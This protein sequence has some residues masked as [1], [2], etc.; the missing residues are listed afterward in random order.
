MNLALFDFD[1]TISS[2]DSFLGFMRT[3]Y[4]GRFL[5]CCALL[6]PRICLFLLGFYSNDKIKECFLE[7]LFKGVPLEQLRLSAERFNRESLSA[8][9]RPAAIKRI[10][11]HR[12][13]GDKI[14]VVSATPRFIL[15]QWC[16]DRRLDLIATEVELDKK[17]RLTG[18]IDGKNCRGPEKVCRI[19]AA[20]DLNDFDEIYAYGDTVSDL[21]M[22]ELAEEHLRF[23]RPF[24]V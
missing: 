4:R 2:A 18:R 6:S 8:M 22:L 3:V 9:E 17:G 24:R 5:R 14:V 1:G 16:R 13:A 7:R 12:A 23:Y 10:D 19:R 15:E 20:Y 21:P 11:Q